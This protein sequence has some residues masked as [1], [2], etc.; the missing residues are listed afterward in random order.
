MA[1]NLSQ[2]LGDHSHLDRVEVESCLDSKRYVKPCVLLDVQPSSDLWRDE[3]LG[4]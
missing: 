2:R 1:N 4:M 3:L